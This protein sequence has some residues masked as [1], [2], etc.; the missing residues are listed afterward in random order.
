MTAPGLPE[1]RYGSPRRRVRWAGA[2]GTVM[3]LLVG[4]TVAVVGYRNLASPPIDSQ[5]LGF[6]LRDESSVEIRFE[7][8]RKDP[9]RAGVCLVRARSLDGDETGRKEV[10]VPPAQDRVVL[11]T[12]VRT[13]RPPVT[14]DVYGC[15]LQVPAYLRPPAAVT[16]G[17]A[18]GG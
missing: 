3:A 7:V 13:S 15:S 17:G 9:S 2:A 6:T 14:G 1:G 18:G 5:Q 8:T 12:V 4:L 11:S 16:P 10:Y